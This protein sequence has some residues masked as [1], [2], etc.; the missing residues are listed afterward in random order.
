MQTSDRVFCVSA[1]CIQK[2][3]DYS[4]HV[5]LSQKEDEHIMTTNLHTHTFRNHHAT[6]SEC[7]YVERAIAC[8]IQTLGF[9]EHAPYRFLNGYTSWWH[10]QPDEMDAYVSAVLA[11]KEEY[12]NEI[13]ILLGIETEYYPSLFEDLLSRLRAYPIDYMI[14]GQHALGDEEGMPGT[15]EESD[16]EEMLAAYV[17]TCITALDFGIFTYLAH[18]DFFSYTGPDE[19]YEREMSRLCRYCADHCIPLEIN[20]KG[21]SGNRRYP[22]EKFFRLAKQ[23]SCRFVAGL[24]AHSPEEIVLPESY[25]RYRDLIISCDL[26]VEDS[27][28]IIKP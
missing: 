28:E 8:G 10:L 1:R 17:D 9:S 27:I 25:E 16:S 23:Y 22:N 18:P 13:Q 14:L 4:G 3:T 26:Q 21:V 6:G 12:K 19:I 7:D 24:D 20:M 2:L 5:I 15:Y 11:V